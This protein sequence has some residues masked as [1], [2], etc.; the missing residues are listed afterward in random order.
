MSSKSD[1]PNPARLVGFRKVKLRDDIGD[2]I[3][4][5]LCAKI[6]P[7][8]VECVVLGSG[9]EKSGVP[10]QFYCNEF[11]AD[12]RLRQLETLAPDFIAPPTV[13]IQDEAGNV[14]I[15]APLD[16]LI[17]RGVKI[18]KLLDDPDG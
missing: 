14:L 13:E 1:K 9:D 15:E 18:R 11:C 2:D 3:R 7:P 8:G 12:Q 6:I 4:C 5:T 16:E 17:R 10:N